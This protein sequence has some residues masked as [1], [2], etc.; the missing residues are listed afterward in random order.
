MIGEYEV[1]GIVRIGTIERRRLVDCPVPGL[2]G[3]YTQDLGSET[4][5]VRI[6]GTLAGDEA[7]DAFLA[8][9]RELFAAGEPVAFVADVTTATEVEQVLLGSLNVIEAAGCADTFRYAITLTQYVEPPPPA[10]DLGFDSLAEL[11]AEL[12]LEALEL[13]DVLQIPDLL[14]A[15]PDISDPTPPLAQILDGVKS[16]MEGLGGAAAAIESVFGS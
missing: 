13:F 15:L 4:V 5:G 16:A 6:E 11:E 2:E 3:G 9:V 7:R 14:G 8:A 10:A 12:G 1:P